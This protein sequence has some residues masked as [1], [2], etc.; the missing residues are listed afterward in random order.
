MAKE[1]NLGLAYDKNT[2]LARWSI[3]DT[4]ST[5]LAG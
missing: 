1:V 5:F 3:K 4:K 2:G